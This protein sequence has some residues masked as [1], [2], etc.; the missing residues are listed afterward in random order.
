MK[1]VYITYYKRTPFSRA[2]PD[3]P[4]KDAYNGISMDVLLSRLIR[5]SLG[6]GINPEDIG[7]VI[8]G[9]AIQAG[10]NWTYGGRHQVLLSDLPVSVPAMSIDRAC[11]SSLNATAI[12]AMEIQ[13]GNSDIVL[14]G[15][16]EHMTHVPLYND[17]YVKYSDELM[18]N[19]KYKKFDMDV[20]Y[21]V[22][23]TAEKLA[24]LNNIS[25]EEMDIFS[26]ESQKLTAK[27]IEN[28]Y[29]NGEI[30]PVTV[31]HEGIEKT[32]NLDQTP[33]PESTLE[34][35]R[36]LKP[37]FVEDGLVTA[38]NS[39]PLSSG[40]SLLMLVSGEKLNEY[41]LKPLAKVIDY[42][43]AGVDPTIMGHGPVPATQKLL[44]KNN[45]SVDDID[46]WEINEAFAVVTLNAMKHLNIDR[47][48]VNIHGGSVAIGHP[49]GATGARIAGTLART[50]Q[51][52]KGNMGIATL[53]VGGG[54]GYS[55]LIE[56]V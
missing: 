18:N 34:G 49:L 44:K 9:C 33:R 51:E 15:G 36:K 6:T 20:S 39:P 42:A 41:G 35:I 37:A 21:H 22:G 23:L 11:S 8:T 14:A 26:F 30:L 28:G 12:G 45:L 3:K 52:K 32:I 16:M 4:E 53:C 38:G 24:R 19:P 29:F 55:M 10:E 46:Y 13:T 54:Q 17:P 31:K 2:K 47:N 48:R 5:D 43:A 7:D 25:R 56:R 1:D 27:S 40:A 50:L